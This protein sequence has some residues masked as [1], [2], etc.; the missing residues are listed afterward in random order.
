MT[1]ETKMWLLALLSLLHR[2]SV[3]E[4]E[5][6]QVLGPPAP[7]VVSPGEDVVLPCSLSPSVSALDQVVRW[8]RVGLIVPICLYAN[9]QYILQDPLSPYWGRTELFTAELARGNVSLILRDVRHSDRGQY[10]C[11]VEFKEAVVDLGVRALGSQPSVSL[12][13]PGGG[14]TQLL[15]RSEGWFPA[16]AVIWTDRDGHDVTSLSSTT[17]EKDSQGLLSVSSYIPVQQESNIFSCLVR[18][19]QPGPDWGP[20]LHIPS[21]Y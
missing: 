1:S 5:T 7:V 9:Q 6:F 14:Q 18:S 19:A 17:V 16:P 12:H 21:K 20:Q 10:K 3:S 11:L 8:L 4:T 13:S 15:C 2:T